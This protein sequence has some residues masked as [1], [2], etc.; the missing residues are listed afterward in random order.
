M[1]KTICILFA[2]FMLS[3]ASI[4]EDCKICIPLYGDVVYTIKDNKV[5]GADGDW[6]YTIK[7]NN[8]YRAVYGDWL[9][10]I[11]DNKIYRPVYGDWLY[12]IEW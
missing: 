8:V 7:D 11:K 10:T 4:A 1:K 9:Y 2:M 3:A 5:Y 6:L 12:T